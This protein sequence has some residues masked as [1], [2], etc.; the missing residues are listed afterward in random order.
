[1]PSRG[2]SA[3][4][5]VP[6]HIRSG[7]KRANQ[8]GSRGLFATGWESCVL[9]RGLHLGAR[10]C[11]RRAR[12]FLLPQRGG[13]LRQPR[14]RCSRSSSPR[15]SSQAWAE[16]RSPRLQYAA[17]PS[18]SALRRR[19]RSA[20]RARKTSG[21]SVCE[22]PF[23]TRC[24]RWRCAFGRGSRFSRRCSRLGLLRKV[25][26]GYCSS[27]QLTFSRRAAAHAR[28]SRFSKGGTRFPS[29]PSFPLR[30]TCSI[31]RGEAWNACSTLR[32]RPSKASSSSHARFASRPP[33]QSF[34]PASSA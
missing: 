22:R 2:R 29:S 14:N 31:K 23:P 25:L 19:A 26:L 33:R 12:T 10:R 15:C 9:L 17:W 32:G 6:P 34:R 4:G 3:K 13:G 8:G 18:P 11:A 16:L 7:L 20:R 28:H 1:M 24:A 27:A 5:H 21:A 30:S